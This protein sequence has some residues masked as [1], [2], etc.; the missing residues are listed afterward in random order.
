MDNLD[1]TTVGI[2]Q[3]DRRAS[4]ASIASEVSASEGTV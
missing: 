3:K 2:L 4:N 1:S